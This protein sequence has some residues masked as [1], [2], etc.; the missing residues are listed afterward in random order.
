MLTLTAVNAGIDF[1]VLYTCKRVGKIHTRVGVARMRHHI[2]SY[3]GSYHQPECVKR[4]AV[5][6][7]C[8]VNACPP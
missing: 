4:Q 1:Y 5:V 3:Q 8:N 2:A 6:N 7:C